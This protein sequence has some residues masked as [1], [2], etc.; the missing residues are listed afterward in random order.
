MTRSGC[1][2][3]SPVPADTPQEGVRSPRVTKEMLMGRLDGGWSQ[4]LLYKLWVVD[5]NRHYHLD[6][7]ARAAQVVADTARAL[8]EREG[9]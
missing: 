2:T 9:E 1:G 7:L 8:A 4:L 6:G 5:E 3:G